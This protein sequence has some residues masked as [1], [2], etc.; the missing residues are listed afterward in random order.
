MEARATISSA[1]VLGAVVVAGSVLTAIAFVGPV[2]YEAKAK[3]LGTARG[4]AAA[5]AATIEAKTAQAARLRGYAWVDREKGVVAL[6]IERA[7]ELTAAELAR[8]AQGSEGG[9]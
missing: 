6:P 3:E 1:H 8:D 9:R 7:M 5:P 2:A 4:F